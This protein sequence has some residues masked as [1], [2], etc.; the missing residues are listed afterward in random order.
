MPSYVISQL[1]IAESEGKDL[2]TYLLTEISEE[3]HLRDARVN[4]Q[5]LQK[6]L[7]KGIRMMVSEVV[8][9]NFTFFKTPLEVRL[10]T[11]INIVLKNEKAAMISSP[12][13]IGLISR[14]KPRN[15]VDSYISTLISEFFS[16]LNVSH[17]P[18]HLNDEEMDASRWGEEARKIKV[19]IYDFGKISLAGS[20]M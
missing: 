14:G 7:G 2:S 3:K 19:D 5:Q 18:Y 20:N 9:L 15:Y 6:E 12:K 17:K 10:E 13:G 1:Q 4:C 11:D 16:S 8:T